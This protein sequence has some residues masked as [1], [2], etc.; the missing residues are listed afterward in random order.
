MAY[1]E[2]LL[3]EDVDHLGHRG[4]VVRVRSG[5]GRNYLLPQG[6]AIEAT[7]GNKRQITEQR[8]VLEK[9]ETRERATAE[10]QADKLNGLELVFERRA[11]EHGILYGSV[12]SMD[13]A[14]ALKEHGY[15]IERR[16]ISLREAIKEIGEYDVA[17]KLHREVNPTVRVLV[18]K[19]GAPASAAAAPA[20]EGG[21]QAAAEGSTPV[22]A[23]AAS[24]AAE[25]AVE[26]ADAS[27]EEPE[28][29]GAE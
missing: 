12:T 16:R 18:R 3:R 4:Q 29:E 23:A 11:G 25:E 24:G 7:P 20:A 13:I 14:A 2:V 22:E 10:G 27:S 1:M 8:R 15:E 5:Y 26:A 17:I 19:E 21:A 6:L 28:E 9:R